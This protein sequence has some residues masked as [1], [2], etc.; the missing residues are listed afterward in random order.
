MKFPRTVEGY[1]LTVGPKNVPNQTE[2][3]SISYQDFVTNKK[4]MAWYDDHSSLMIQVEKAPLPSKAAV[5]PF[6][7]GRKGSPP[8][9]A[10]PPF[11]AVTVRQ[12]VL[13]TYYTTC[14]TISTILTILTILTIPTAGRHDRP[15]RWWYG[16]HG[17]HGGPRVRP[18]NGD[19]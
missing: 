13:H 12:R 19:V 17:R 3:K 7:T 18:C 11:A 16:G 2:V 5:P 10:L 6:A 9:S 8:I 4:Q 15:P 1:R 14:F